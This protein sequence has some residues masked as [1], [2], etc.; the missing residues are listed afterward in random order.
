VFHYI[1]FTFCLFTQFG[2]NF[3]GV[4]YGLS[5]TADDGMSKIKQEVLISIMFIFHVVGDFFIYFNFLSSRF[6]LWKFLIVLMV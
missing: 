6:R 1:Y 3:G 5:S 2:S 4:S